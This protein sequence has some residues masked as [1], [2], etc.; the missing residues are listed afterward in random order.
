MSGP[1]GVLIKTVTHLSRNNPV[2]TVT[3]T[4]GTNRSAGIPFSEGTRVNLFGFSV[5][6]L[7]LGLAQHL[8][9]RVPVILPPGT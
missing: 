9:Q 8:I 3:V 7:G 2:N 4:G 1:L 5:S 6:I